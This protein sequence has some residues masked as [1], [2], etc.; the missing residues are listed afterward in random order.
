VLHLQRARSRHTAFR[1]A[2]ARTAHAAVPHPAEQSADPFG[3]AA[4]AAFSDL[5]QW[6]PV[7]AGER[8]DI[9]VTRSALGDPR[10]VGLERQRELS[11]FMTFV[12]VQR[13]IAAALMKTLLPL[14]LMTLIL[15][16]SLFFSARFASEKITVSIT[17]ALSGAVLLSEIN[18]QLGEI[19]YT[20]G[21]EYVFYVYFL[22]CLLSIL[23]AET[24]DRLRLGERAAVAAERTAQVLFLVGILAATLATWLAIAR[25]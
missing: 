6:K 9:L 2:P 15:F 12:D 14:G 19:G 11:G 21:I 18:N 10:L 16:A 3:I 17:A 8:R 24:S 23:V 4:A 25:S 7:D 22:L 13:R 5:T 1:D 20:V